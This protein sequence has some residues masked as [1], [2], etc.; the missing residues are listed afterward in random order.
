MDWFG[1]FAPYSLYH[2]KQTQVKHKY[3][4][5][6]GHNKYHHLNNSGPNIITK[7]E[8]TLAWCEWGLAPLLSPLPVRHRHRSKGVTL[9]ELWADITLECSQ[10]PHTSACD[11][12]W[13]R[14]WDSEKSTL[15]SELQNTDGVFSRLCFPTKSP[16]S[17]KLE[18]LQF[19]MREES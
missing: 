12:K 16:S 8:A 19:P 10:F 1:W 15:L 3:V 11:L 2:K 14:T 5:R 7:V 6:H 18:S 9:P 17:F 4:Q 13:G